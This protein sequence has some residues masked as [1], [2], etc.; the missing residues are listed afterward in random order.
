MKRT[1]M[2]KIREILRLY[3]QLNYSNRTIANALNIGKSTVNTFIKKFNNSQ[4]SYSDI[5]N[6]NDEDILE[7]LDSAGK[8]VSDKYKYL[9][10]RFP[11]YL[12]ELSKTGVT[13]KLL[14]EEYI[15]DNPDGYKLS[16]F[17]YH[18]QIYRGSTKTSM[19]IEHKAGDKMFIDFTG[20]HLYLTDKITQKI[21]PVEVFIAILPASS[22]TYVEVVLSQE[23][24][25][26]IKCTENA[27]WYFGGVPKAI[28]PDCLKAAVT[29]GSK[30]EPEINRD[31]Q[32]F[33][34]HYS[35]AVLP[36]RPHS[37][38]DK[39]MVEGAVKIVYS[40]IFA[41]LRDKVFYSFQELNK[42]IF[43]LLL[44]Y[45]SRAMQRLRISRVDLFNEIEKKELKALPLELYEFKS[46]AKLTVAFNY[47][48]FLTKD[49]H[50]YS[51]PFKY[52]KKKVDVM[53][54]EGHIE[55]YFNNIRIAFHK[56]SDKANG[57]TT[58]KEHMPPNHKF[59]SEWSPE[60]FLSW[61]AKIGVN[62]KDFINKVIESKEHPEQAYRVCLGV[63]NQAK[64]F[65][66]FNLD[67]A[68]KKALYYNCY[69]LKFIRNALENNALEID[70][71]NLFNKITVEHSNIRG[72]NYYN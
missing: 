53:Y 68:C 71:E 65:T 55:V 60:R 47:H 59:Y 23:K 27:L 46:F 45:N 31:F 12:K 43:N 44:E 28:M 20:K 72:K 18:F 2:I 14:W 11:E 8:K 69:T 35:T 49:H 33:A 50:Y 19:R 21:S 7:M 4:L 29:K 56:R 10:G 38:K 64:R 57:Y 42:S 54:T 36:A 30:Y 22:Y 66:A 13:V 34:K 15:K 41:K 70:D 48:I 5:H 37:P 32:D 58:I 51:V 39:A 52:I 62:T 61:A 67:K 25:N 17:A 24:H 9:H 1:I 3:T 6:L 16:Q 40:W 26:L 63:L